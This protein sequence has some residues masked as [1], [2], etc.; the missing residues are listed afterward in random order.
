[1]IR[2]ARRSRLLLAATV[3][4]ELYVVTSFA[5]F[6]VLLLR[7][8]SFTATVA[9][10]PPSEPPPVPFSDLAP[11]PVVAFL[12]G[13]T[14]MT[15]FGLG[16][17]AVYVTDVLSPRSGLV[18][19]TRTLWV[20]ALLFGGAVTMPMYWWRHLRPAQLSQRPTSRQPTGD[21]PHR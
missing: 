2:S 10:D 3:V 5:V 17:L 7:V 13:S 14:V 12:V 4:W 6:A 8:V 15:A 21:T 9:A 18:G 11:A 1:M 16:L 19:D 20:V